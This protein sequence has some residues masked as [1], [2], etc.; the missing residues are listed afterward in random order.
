MAAVREF[1]RVLT[2]PLGAPAGS[3]KRTGANGLVTEQVETYLE[4]AR[5]QGFDALV[6]I[7][8]EIPAAAGRSW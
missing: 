2:V 5:E 8:N 6:T 7:S 1:G 4:V 3:A